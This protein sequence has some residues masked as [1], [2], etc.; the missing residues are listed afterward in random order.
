ME[1][2]P[3]FSIVMPAYNCES[4][5]GLTIDSVL[6]Q[7]FTEFELIIINDGSADSTK[8]VIERYHNKDY[9]VKFKTIQNGGPGN[10]RNKGIELANGNYLLFIDSDDVMKEH[11]LS[12]YASYINEKNVD[13]II[14]SYN[15]KVLD[16]D[17]VVDTREV[18]A[19]ELM[20][21]TDKEFLNNIYPLMNK[22]LMYVVWNKLYKLSIVKGNNVVFPAY[23]SCEDRLF[24]IQYFH[25]VNSCKVVNDVLYNYS[26]DGRNSLTNKYFDNKFDTFVEFYRELILLTEKNRR[27]SSALFLKGVMS[28]II[29]LHSKSCK[30]SYRDKL[31]YIREIVNFPDVKKAADETLLDTKMR[32]VM[33]ILFES[34]SVLLNYTAS[35][36]MYSISTTSPKTIEKF[37]RRF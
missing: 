28:C 15:L 31:E 3:F 21:N 32:K 17:V 13:L 34:K 10:A 8:Q 25:H 11:T 23:N 35:K 5:I 33:K 24:N 22:Q 18:E 16:G 26:F 7:S 9:R 2:T 1:N 37:K 20:I 36:I 19:P 27:G 12:T 30:L 6:A 4:S 14:S 29:P